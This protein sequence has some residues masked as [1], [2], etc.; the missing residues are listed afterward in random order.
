MKRWEHRTISITYDRK[1][2][3]NWVLAYTG[4]QPLVGLQAIL[5]AY[6]SDG[7][8]LIGL[9]PDHFE[10]SPGF[11]RWTIDPTVYRATFKRRVAG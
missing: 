10:A 11:G 1:Q 6:E 3:R 9:L 2:H 8:E 5:E 7:W 4:Q